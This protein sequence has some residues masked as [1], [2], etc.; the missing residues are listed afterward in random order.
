VKCWKIRLAAVVL[1]PMALA[2]AL[3]SCEWD[4]H[5]TILG[6]TTRPNYD[7]RYKT[8]K[9][10]IFKNPT[11]WAVVPVPGLEMELT[12]AIVR[13][14]E[15]KTP[16][17]V[18]RDNADTELT[19]T[20]KSFTLA[21]LSYNQLFE[22]REVETTLLAEVAWRD[23]RT[24]KY[25]TAPRRVPGMPVPDDALPAVPPL[26]EGAMG[27]VLAP[28]PATPTSPLNTGLTE[29]PSTPGND[30]L[31]GVPVVP[32]APAPPLA[33]QLVRSVGRYIPELGQSIATAQKEN[34]DRMA[35]QIV[36]MMESPW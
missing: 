36:S 22:R 20:I 16:Y 8:V 14:I 4:G 27:R 7:T 17:K 31:P 28:I 2:L 21:I 9:V 25:L 1:V 35:I 23:L 12:K 34:V 11:F 10:N 6:Y 19:G 32:G 33:L 30:A 5:F 3:P 18:V 24:G 26:A 15:A 13:E 29:P